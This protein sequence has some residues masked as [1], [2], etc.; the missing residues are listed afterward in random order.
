[1]ETAKGKT[2]EEVIA[3]LANRIDNYERYSGPHSRVM[4]ELAERLARRFGLAEPDV[5]SIAEAAMLHDIG[6]YAMGPA[7]HPSPGPLSFQE[8]IDLWRHPI[9]GEQQMAKRDATRHAQLL[10]R[11]HHEWWNGSGYPDTLAFEDIPIGARILRAVE[12]YSALVSDRPYRPALEGEQ[13]LDALRSSA[14][15]ECDPYVIKALLA[16]LE[17]LRAQEAEGRSAA[18]PYPEPEESYGP[19][20]A[21]GGPRPEAA[22]PSDR[23]DESPDDDRQAFSA[24]E[25]YGPNSTIS[26]ALNI[27]TENSAAEAPPEYGQEEHRAEARHATRT[28]LEAPR[29]GLEA[30]PPEPAPSPL[31]SFDKLFAPAGARDF[32][33]SENGLWQGWKRSR[34]NNKTLLGF[35]ASVLRQ[36]DFRSIAIAFSGWA[37]IDWYLKA[38]N[39]VII[40]NDPRTWAAAASRAAVEAETPLA[41]EQIS[42]LLEDVYVPGTRLGNPSLRQWFGETDAWWMD[43]LRRNIAAIEDETL[44]AQALVLGLQT[45]DYALSFDEETRD[46]KRPLTT[47]FWRLAGRAITGSRGHSNNRSHNEPVEEFARHARA[48]LFYIMLPSAHADGGDSENR[49]RW[50]ESWVRGTQ[51]FE[52][53][54]THYLMTVPQSKKSYLS[55]ADRLL[56]SASHIKTWAVGYQEP[57]LASARDISEL[58]EEHRPIRATYSKDLTEVAGGLRSYIIV[59][60]KTPSR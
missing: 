29:A 24:P 9:V 32:A 37:R 47:V 3:R 36:L 33:E 14:G 51:D 35:E 60:D 50:R 44:R 58:I 57:G 17:E 42:M 46:L 22:Q 53:D 43:N 8:R 26:E 2:R 28:G 19:M 55:M 10:V 49:A 6:L 45:G 52:P 21:E 5:R 4:A 30:P 54:D 13:A 20:E 38:W 15:I 25:G 18:R 48:D 39:K 23:P 41:E 34:Y 40:S 16:L 31:P 12:L 59:A 56:R 7:Y 1:M 11:W 27:S